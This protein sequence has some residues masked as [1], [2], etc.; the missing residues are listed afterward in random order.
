[1][2]AVDEEQNLTIHFR[3][4]SHCAADGIP[5]LFAFESLVGEIVP[6]SKLSWHR[7]GLIVAVNFVDRF[8]ELSPK[9]TTMHPCFIHDNLKQPRTKSTSI[10]EL[11]YVQERLQGTFLDRLLRICGVTQNS[12]RRGKHQPGIG[13]NEV[14]E[15]CLLARANTRDDLFFRRDV[16][17]HADHRL[18]ISDS[19]FKHDLCCIV[20]TTIQHD[21]RSKVRLRGM[22]E[23]N[24]SWPSVT[25][26]SSRHL[27]VYEPTV[28]DPGR[29][30]NL[31]QENPP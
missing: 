2:V 11:G 19:R 1:M 21:A 14:M 6:I 12:Q 28:A 13:A 7:I 29:K 4:V 5:K 3:Q 9:V 30:P 22:D 20:L 25:F 15:T 27:P 16:G 26:A 23:L 18:Q 17:T 24:I 10:F 8:V 31:N